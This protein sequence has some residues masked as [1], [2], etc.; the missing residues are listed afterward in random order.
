MRCVLMLLFVCAL[1][2]GEEALVVDGLAQRIL[3]L[4]KTE[5]LAG[6]LPPPERYPT[7]DLGY[8]PAW[9]QRIQWQET[10]WEQLDRGQCITILD[11]LYKHA[12]NQWYTNMR[13]Y[14]LDR[15][16]TEQL[17]MVRLRDRD[18]RKHMGGMI[19]QRWAATFG[20]D[21]IAFGRQ[22]QEAIQQILLEV[23]KSLR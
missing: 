8:Q 18:P 19:T 2:P 21:A 15:S 5:R 10:P 4:A 20:R 16:I 17:D 3:T 23:Q 11:L 22:R 12:E 7:P 6:R 1:L 9:L 13:A 14:R